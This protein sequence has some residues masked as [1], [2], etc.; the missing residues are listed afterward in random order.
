MIA[1]VA[2]VTDFGVICHRIQMIC[3]SSVW[4][5]QHHEQ[6]RRKKTKRAHTYIQQT[7]LSAQ[8]ET[9]EQVQNRFTITV[10]RTLTNIH[11]AISV[12][13]NERE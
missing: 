13:V 8:L 3:R 5:Y 11:D 1:T 9:A 7:R 6:Q 4:P 10:T 2:T 12:L